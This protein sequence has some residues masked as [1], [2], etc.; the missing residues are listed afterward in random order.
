MFSWHGKL[1]G[2]L[3]NVFCLKIMPKMRHFLVEMWDYGKD[4]KMRDCRIV[5]TC[6]VF[7]RVRKIMAIFSDFFPIEIKSKMR[8]FL[9]EMR[10]FPN[11]CGMVD[12]YD[13]GIP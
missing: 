6:R 9:V 7:K 11:N 4:C 1:S 12:T 13:I 3:A 5:G 8:D 10:D 2:F